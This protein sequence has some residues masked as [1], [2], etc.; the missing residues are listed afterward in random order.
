MAKIICVN[1]YKHIYDKINCIDRRRNA[2][3]YTF[4]F[5]TRPLKTSLRT[6]LC[7]KKSSL[8]GQANFK[9]YTSW[10][11]HYFPCEN[12]SEDNKI[13]EDI[14]FFLVSWNCPDLISIHFSLLYFFRQ[15]NSSPFLVAMSSTY[16]WAPGY[17][18][19]CDIT[20]HT[21][22]G[23]WPR[24]ANKPRQYGLLG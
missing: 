22:G 7:S 21:A 1:A 24:S 13:S 16:T 17:H 5:K 4:C 11:S 14:F 19:L 6:D 8:G 3:T 10:H 18:V 20:P 2:H 12:M 23:K 15:P 9:L